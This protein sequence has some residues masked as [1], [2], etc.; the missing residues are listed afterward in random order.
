MQVT[1]LD[2]LAMPRKAAEDQGG[3]GG[4]SAQLNTSASADDRSDGERMQD[5]VEELVDQRD[6]LAGTQTASALQALA[7]AVAEPS[8]F[9]QPSAQIADIA[10]QAAK[11][12][13]PRTVV[14]M[15]TSAECYIEKS[16]RRHV[17]R[18]NTT[19]DM[20]PVCT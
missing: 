10:R 7:D 19:A 13:G 3:G 11:V 17:C 8:V 4:G 15:F 1:Q 2:Q 18:T 9:L 14:G 12:G 6:V 16:I 5:D 20:P